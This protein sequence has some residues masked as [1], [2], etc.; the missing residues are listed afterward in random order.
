MQEL[1]INKVQLEVRTNNNSFNTTNNNNKYLVKS[2]QPQR[3]CTNS[4]FHR[5]R[6]KDTINNS[7]E[8]AVF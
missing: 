3:P 1:Q 6:V 7:F 4:F 8:N 5:R 2:L